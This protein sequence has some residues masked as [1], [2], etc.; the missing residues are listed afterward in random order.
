[1]GSLQSGIGFFLDV[2]VDISDGGVILLPEGAL[3]LLAS[4]LT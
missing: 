3:P 1:M 4:G 2:C